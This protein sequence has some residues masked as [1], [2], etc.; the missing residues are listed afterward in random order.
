MPEQ[1]AI[2]Q[3]VEHIIRNDFLV[4]FI[5]AHTISKSDFYVVISNISCYIAAH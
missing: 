2:A 1:A 5:A 3:S 4:I